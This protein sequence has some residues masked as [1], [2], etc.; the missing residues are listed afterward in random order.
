MVWWLV[1]DTELRLAEEALRSERE[2]TAFLAEVSETLSATLNV[3]RCVEATTRLAVQHL[4]DAAVLIA[5]AAGRRLPVTY[6]TPEG[7]CTARST[8]TRRRCRG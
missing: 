1:D 2:R 3:E 5:P 6:S 7:R 8:R 4:A